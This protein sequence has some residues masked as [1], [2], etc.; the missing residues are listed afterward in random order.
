MQRRALLPNF[1][2][3]KVLIA[4]ISDLHAQGV[5]HNSSRDFP[6]PLRK[7]SNLK[8]RSAACRGASSEFNFGVPAAAVLLAFGPCKRVQRQKLNFRLTLWLLSK[9][10]NPTTGPTT[11]CNIICLSSTSYGIVRAMGNPAAQRSTRRRAL[12]NGPFQMKTP[13][14]VE[15]GRQWACFFWGG[16]SESPVSRRFWR[17]LVLNPAIEQARGSNRSE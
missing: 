11:T 1:Q 8:P 12:L 17:G 16:A 9:L 14:Q 5:Q 4:I 13:L 7:N 6:T 3:P 10:A 2:R 15:G